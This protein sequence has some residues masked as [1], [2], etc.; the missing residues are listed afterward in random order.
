MIIR[1]FK[2]NDIDALIVC[3]NSALPHDAI[4]KKQFILK[5]LLEENFDAD[6]LFI[7]EENGKILGFINCV[8]RKVPIDA[9]TPVDD[10][11]G[12]ISAF[13]VDDSESLFEVG[14]A[15]LESAEAYFSSH[16]KSVIST[17]YY[18]LYLFQGVSEEH[19]PKYIELFEKR[20]YSSSRSI[21]RRLELENYM[22]PENIPD[23]KER[24]LESGIY[25]GAMKDEYVRSLVD[26]REAFN[27]GSGAYEFKLRLLVLDYERIRIA[28]KD[29]RIIGVC[30]F[31]DPYGSAE[32]FG[33]FV[34]SKEYQGMG[35][36]SV[37]MNECLSEM[38]KRGLSGAWMQWTPRS[39]AADSM[40]KKIGFKQTKTYVTFN[41]K[42]EESVK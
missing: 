18:P 1:N 42:L 25:V 36:G 35:I 26:S 8:Y 11:E 27:S 40:Y 5:V 37:L 6:G 15:L 7:A 20:G 19:C 32:R 34:V 31:G 13:A 29:G 4:D 21:A 39:G 30:V 22:P 38:K 2:G 9:Y 24:L 3:Y 41:K 12:W 23:K 14:G 10:R 28:A 33:P 16:G 17:G